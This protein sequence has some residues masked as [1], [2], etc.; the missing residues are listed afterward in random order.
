MRF[1]KSLEGEGVEYTRIAENLL[2]GRGYVGI[3]ANGTQLNFPPLYPVL[4]ALVSLVLPSAEIAARV[5]NV[6][7][8]AALII[9]VF[10][11]ADELYGR[12]AAIV[13]T[14]VVTFHP[15]LLVGSASTFSE[16][17]YLTLLLSA[18]FWLVRWITTQR[19]RNAAFAGAF[20]GLAY[21]VRPEA[22]LLAGEFTVLGLVAAL[23]VKERRALLL[24][25]AAV[26]PLAFA[27]VASPNVIFLTRATGKLRLEAKG[28][29]AYEWGRRINQGMSYQEAVKGIGED[30]SEQGVFMR[31][32]RDVI[33]GASYTTREYLAFVMRAVRR[34][35]GTIDR[36]IVDEK[37]L[38]S[39]L[40]FGLIV[41]ALFRTGWGK[42]RL[43]MDGVLLIT[44]GTVIAVLGTVQEIWFRYFFS[45]LGIFAIWMAK[46][47]C[48]VGDWAAATA[49]S[50]TGDERRRQLI[51]TAATGLSI[52]A[53]LGL[54]WSRIRDVGQFSEAACAE[55]VNAGRWLAKQSS[56]HKWVMAGEDRVAYYAGADLMYLPYARSDLAIRYVA[57]RHPDY[58]VLEDM[59]ADGFPYTRE[60]LTNGIPDTRA[61]LI[62]EERGPMARIK[63]YRWRDPAP[64]P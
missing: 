51:R 57:K 43:L 20:F 27:V 22:F 54:A 48:D 59:T 38:G 37:A 13:A 9:P 10:K 18:V 4:I 2:A 39:P 46:G 44:T 19:A 26:L 15:V 1:G 63:I 8:G 50:M 56:A 62:H 47:A 32:N 17:S 40:L 3:F 16:V 33:N 55:C 12:R 64:S 52:V 6:L 35:V 11:I 31:P 25:G 58:I 7:F 61:E 24:R 60:W 53:V 21:L 14:I 45:L 23:L 5:V 42:Q 28:T 30:L 34:N 49:G 36:T 29:L 41:L